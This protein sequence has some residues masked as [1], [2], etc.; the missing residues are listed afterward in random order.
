[1][2]SDARMLVVC[3]FV[4]AASSGVTPYQQVTLQALVYHGQT[5]LGLAVPNILLLLLCLHA[6]LLR[7]GHAAESAAVSATVAAQQLQQQW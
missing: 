4:L 3:C 6:S 2:A 5:S 7:T 1:M